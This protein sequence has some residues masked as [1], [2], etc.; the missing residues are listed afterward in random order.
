MKWQIPGYVPIRALGSGA[1][2]EVV[3]ARHEETGTSVAIKYLSDALRS[4]TDHLAAFR[5][6]A[7]LL[8]GLDDEHVVRLY[9]YVEFDEGA[10]IVMELVNGPTLR[11]MLR[12][13]G[14]IE[15]EA[16]LAVLHGSLL[17][18]AAAHAVDV[19]HRDYKPENVLIDAAGQSKLADFG[20]A[21][22]AGADRTTIAGTQTYLA[23]ECWRDGVPSPA[24]DV[25]A[26]TA[27]FFE[28]L[29]GRPPFVAGNADALRRQHANAPIPADDVPKPLQDLVRRGL[30]KEPARRPADAAKF[31]ADLEAIAVGAYGADW[32]EKGRRHLARRAALLSLLWP[33]PAGAAATAIAR[34]LFGRPVGSWLLGAVPLAAILIGGIGIAVSQPGTG[35]PVADQN[36]PLATTSVTPSHTRPAGSPISTVTSSP[37]PSRSRTPPVSVTPTRSGSAT[38]SRSTPTPR[39]HSSSTSRVVPPPT[40]SVPHPP[41]SS[42]VQS[43]KVTITTFVWSGGTTAKTIVVVSTATRAPVVLTLNFSESDTDGG[44]QTLSRSSVHTLSGH[45]SYSIDDFNTYGSCTPFWFLKAATSPSASNGTQTASTSPEPPC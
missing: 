28:C 5:A 37:R 1:S 10:G 33:L 31:A 9:E 12:E 38:A 32:L 43:I 26:A 27:T 6:E 14:P 3:L 30:A 2:G 40:R 11:A 34:T 13:Q 39:P 44:P 36:N 21:V 8:A 19:V 42:P 18:L 35:R 22:P 16:A 20:I 29:T 25:Y 7:R 15:P 4:D 45:R 24:A 41:S 17:G 23:P